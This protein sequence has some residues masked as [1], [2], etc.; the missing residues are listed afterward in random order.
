MT[1]TGPLV[2]SGF[3]GDTLQFQY[4]QYNPTYPSVLVPIFTDPAL[5]VTSDTVSYWIGYGEYAG[6][7]FAYLPNIAIKVVDMTVKPNG[8]APGQIFFQLTSITPESGPY[9]QPPPAPA[10]EFQAQW[11]VIIASIVLSLVVLRVRRQYKPQ[12]PKLH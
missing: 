7:N 8:Y 11:I 1:F 2:E 12:F 6:V 9:C 10:P 5:T 3:Y 4:F